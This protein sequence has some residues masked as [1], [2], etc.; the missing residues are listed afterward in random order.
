MIKIGDEIKKDTRLDHGII[1]RVFKNQGEVLI[2]WTGTKTYTIEKI[3]NI[4]LIN[5]LK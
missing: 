4:T 1:K 3:N 5:Y 2:Q